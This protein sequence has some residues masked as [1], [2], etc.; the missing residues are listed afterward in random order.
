MHLNKNFDIK[1]VN[2]TFALL[3]ITMTLFSGC[4]G[5]HYK[6]EE[7]KIKDEQVCWDMIKVNHND[8]KKIEAALD[9][10]INTF[11][12]DVEQTLASRENSLLLINTIRQN[13]NDSK[14]ISPAYI[15][16]LHLSIVADEKSNLP[17]ARSMTQNSCWR[18]INTLNAD[19]PL[20]KKIK[21]KGVM[22]EL[23][24]SLVLYDTYYYIVSIV[25]ENDRLRRFS[26]QSDSGYDILEDNLAEITN[27]F[28]QLS[29][30]YTVHDNV[31]R[32]KD[33]KQQIMNF[34]KHDDNIAYLDLLI[35]TS[36]S[37]EIFL[38]MEFEK[39][40]NT[41][42]TQRNKNIRDNLSEL[43]RSAIN[44]ISQFFGNAAGSFEERKGKLYRDAQAEAIV[45]SHLQAGDILV[46]KTPFRLTDKMIP[47]HWG[48][49]AIW[50]GTEKEL[51]ELG[52][53]NHEVVTKYHQQIKENK[54]VAE[55]LRQG[56]T[57]NSLE[58]FMNVD[59]LGI[60][61]KKNLSPQEKA[62][63]IILA[64]RQ[65]GK[66][67]DFNFD[68]ETTDKIVCS[69]LVYI[70]Y[71]KISWPTDNVVGRYTISPDN[72][73]IKALNNGP[74]QLELFYHDGKQVMNNTELVMAEL[75][76]NQ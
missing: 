44:G 57:L 36:P 55:S 10:H 74:L 48:H 40:V 29:N 9:L 12:Q 30:L 27:T 72:I 43:N 34:S 47:G 75:M 22:L 49:A 13:T 50:I 8:P 7:Q 33:H 67:Y 2:T 45:V 59:D 28:L 73:A 65:I 11:Q 38:K 14:P 62:D 61:R 68:V 42:M 17:I 58:H 1:T 35:R 21:I 23:A 53:W 37:Y 16:L 15:E 60:I 25:N 41:R 5:K 56:T 76:N 54:L 70:A 6:H 20:S 24:A 19:E 52:I 31:T 39:V 46:E 4:V 66:A 18:Q 3:I 69:Q 63:A 71:S 26:N 32:Y 51:K 64:L